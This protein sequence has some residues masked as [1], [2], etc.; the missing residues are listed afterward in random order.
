M[1]YKDKC[2]GVCE[3]DK[4]RLKP[5]S[6]SQSAGISTPPLTAIMNEAPSQGW[7]LDRW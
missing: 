6:E 3:P 1:I 5:Y 4:D 7:G 2:Q